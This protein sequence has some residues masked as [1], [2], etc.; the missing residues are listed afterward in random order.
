M[1]VYIYKLTRMSFGRSREPYNQA[2]RR[3]KNRKVKP[4]RAPQ[5][6]IHTHIHIY[7]STH[8]HTHT[9]TYKRTFFCRNKEP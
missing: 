7:T 1:Y 6:I 4:K 5:Y 3:D 2:F 8:L 9:H